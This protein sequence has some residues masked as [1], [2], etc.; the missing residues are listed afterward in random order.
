[1]QNRKAQLNQ[2][3]IEALTIE[4]ADYPH[5]GPNE[6]VVNIKATSLNFLDLMVIKGDFP[7]GLPYPYTPLSDGAG[8][9][10]ETG[11]AVTK[12]KAGDRVALQ[13]VQNWMD[14]EGIALEKA[15]RVG[16]QTQGVLADFVCIPDYG[17]VKLPDSL[18]YE[19]AATLPIAGVT[20]W[21]GLI[22]RAQLRLGQTVLV[23]G[24]GGVSMFALQLAKSAGARVIA[25]TSS[26]EKA[27]RLLKM[28]ADAV[29]N[30]KTSPQWH[31]EVLRLTDGE[32]VDVTL[33]IA[34]KATIVQSLQSVKVNGVVCT[35]GGVSGPDMLL[36]VYADLNLNFKR[37]LGFAVG[38]AA[39]FNALLRAMDINRIHPIIDKVY[40][41]EQVREAFRYL[42]SGQ[43]LGKVVVTL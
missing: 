28:G 21:E 31:K 25:T 34:G 41:L 12:W 33:D 19:E 9:V 6:V 35:A 11:E 27:D 26:D 36:N 4:Q 16:W 20:A 39:S 14:G 13:Y 3:G 15:V 42:E 17:L 29:I 2:T 32:G 23:Q 10:V 38:S 40:P 37:L 22:N 18:S 1:M 8:V 24:T 30:Y 5:P 7:T 43:H